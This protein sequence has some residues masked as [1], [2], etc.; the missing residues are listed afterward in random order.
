M[1]R[2]A[3][4]LSFSGSPGQTNAGSPVLDRQGN[5][6]GILGLTGE[7]GAVSFVVSVS[8]IIRLLGACGL[9]DIGGMPGEVVGGVLGG[10]PGGLRGGTP[11]GVPADQTNAAYTEPGSASGNLPKIIR[12]SG[13]V[14]QGQAVRRV[15]PI[16]PPP[17]RE[18]SGAVVVEV[19][20]D[21]EG[22][23]ISATPV[24]GHPLLKEAAAAAARGWKFQPTK[25]QGVPVKVIGTI[26]F[27]FQM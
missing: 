14:L 24:S 10:N 9:P 27:N 22:Y 3:Y 1:V 26:T 19:T 21:E 4:Y 6:V 17:A 12:K 2:G 23:V 7:N 8:S 13:G 11:S 25:L 20:I 16:Y 15:E 5:L 18:V